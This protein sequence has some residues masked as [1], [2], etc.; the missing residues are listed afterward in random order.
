[1]TA[2]LLLGAA[3]VGFA[4]WAMLR[5]SRRE[6]PGP[7]NNWRNEDYLSREADGTWAEGSTYS[8]SQPPDSSG[9]GL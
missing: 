2:L 6:K 7:S 8:K 4:L 1:V 3:I 5:D 9:L